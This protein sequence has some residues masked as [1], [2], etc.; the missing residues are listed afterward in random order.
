MMQ[1]L[2]ESNAKIDELELE[3]RDFKAR[4][5]ESQKLITEVEQAKA[6]L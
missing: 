1:Q 2:E 3:A 6:R 5:E 4:L